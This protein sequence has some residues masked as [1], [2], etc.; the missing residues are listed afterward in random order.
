[1]SRILRREFEIDPAAVRAASRRSLLLRLCGVVVLVALFGAAVNTWIP[2]SSRRMT[3]SFAVAILAVY[4][5]VEVSSLQWARRSAQSMVLRLA[6]D[7]L[8]LW[9]GANSHRMPYTELAIAHVRQSGGVVKTIELRGGNSGR[10]ALAGFHDMDA[11]AE[12]L[13]AAIASARA[14]TRPRP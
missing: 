8:E 6:P 14:D 11:L 9:I 3:W 2:E 4:A 13:T 10:V 5:A 12:S 7:A 1:M